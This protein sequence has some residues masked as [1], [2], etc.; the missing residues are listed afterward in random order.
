MAEKQE[1]KENDICS[2]IEIGEEDRY[3]RDAGCLIGKKVEFIRPDSDWYGKNGFIGC[4]V[5]FLEDIER[6]GRKLVIM[7]EQLTFIQ[8]KLEKVPA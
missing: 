8:I 2:I 6:N 4:R 3:Y 1:L 7:G 5:S